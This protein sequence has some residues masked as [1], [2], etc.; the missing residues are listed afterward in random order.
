[1]GHL[2]SYSLQQAFPLALPDID[3]F[4]NLRRPEQTL[5]Q[6][7]Q[8]FSKSRISSSSL[9]AQFPSHTR[10]E[11]SF[12]PAGRLDNVDS[13][14]FAAENLRA[15]VTKVD[16]KGSGFSCFGRK[17]KSQ[18]RSMNSGK[19]LADFA[20]KLYNS[21][22]R[23]SEKGHRSSISAGGIL[24]Y[25][26]LEILPSIDLLPRP[27]LA[28]LQ[29]SHNETSASR[30]S[31]HKAVA[32]LHDTASSLSLKATH[33][34]EETPVSDPACHANLQDTHQSKGIL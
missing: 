28:A 17:K 5:I 14:D 22:V 33:H 8:H 29:S 11:R 16:K 32:S 6:R 23:K 13:H 7:N 20:S 30:H 10:A 26:E 21:D 9:W 12:S 34:T 15:K 19:R 25:P 24:E 27:Y 3:R 31:L 2:E 18:T 1:M 4:A